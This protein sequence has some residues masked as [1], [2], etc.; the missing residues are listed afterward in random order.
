MWVATAM[1]LHH[2]SKKLG[3][4]RYWIIVSLHLVYFLSQFVTLFL[5]LFD[6]LTQ[7]N[8][9]FGVLLSI[10]FPISKAVGGI[11]FGIG[12]WVTSRTI[13]KSNIVRQYLVITAIGF[14]LLFVSDQAVTL[15]TTPYPPFGIASVSAVGLSS[16]LILVGLHYSVVSMSDDAMLLL[17]Q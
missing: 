13:N 9:I 6:P 5:K 10:I 15:I 4:I 16:Y 7:E 1:F 12:F 11:L 14:V 2:Y 17:N 8:P 3:K